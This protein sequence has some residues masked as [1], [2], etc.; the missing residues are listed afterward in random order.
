M[1]VED[2]GM[3]GMIELM[4]G[5]SGV[6]MVLAVTI[7]RQCSRWYVPLGEHRWVA[8]CAQSRCVLSD[9]L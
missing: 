7:A 9:A 4:I 6:M 5:V 2:K 1:L 3:D 8:G